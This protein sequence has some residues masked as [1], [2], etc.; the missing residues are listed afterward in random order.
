MRGGFARRRPLLRA[1]VVGGG[2]YMAG[3]A[4]A[5]RSAQ[6]ADQEAYQD[7]R[8]SD[9]EQAQQQPQAQQPQYQ[10]QAPVPEPR[11][12]SSMLGQLNQLAQ[13]HDSGA[14]N[15]A[16]FAAAKAKLLA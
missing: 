15:D 12:D 4:A 11:P 3:R 6:Q 10:Q 1:A 14:L 16:E 5:N 8:L 9:L 2:A 13:L 7:Q